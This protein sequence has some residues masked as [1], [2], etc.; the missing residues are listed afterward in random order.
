MTSEEKQQLRRHYRSA[1]EALS[2]S[3]RERASAGACALLQD[4]KAWQEA[5]SIFFYSPLPNE[6]DIWA[7]VPEALKLGKTVLLP[8][9]EEATGIYGAAQV[10]DIGADLTPGKFGIQEPGNHTAWHPLNQLDLT[11]VPGVAFDACGG[12]LGRGRG[13]YDRLLAQVSGAKCGIA[14]DEQLAPHIPSEPHDIRLNCILTPTRWIAV[15]PSA[16]E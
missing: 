2:A 14:F 10:T 15:K 9:F 6:L 4:Q 13:F 11:L 16:C 1:V 5:R 8:R 7:L 12:R 3:A